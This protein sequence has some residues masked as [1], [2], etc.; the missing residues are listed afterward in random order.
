MV[1][2]DINK[3]VFD[4]GNTGMNRINCLMMLGLG[5]CCFFDACNVGLV[6]HFLIVLAKGLLMVLFINVVIAVYGA[7][8]LSM[9][10]NIL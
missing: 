10:L 1:Y 4:V 9:L 2:K 7:V 8:L 3:L 6:F 5:I